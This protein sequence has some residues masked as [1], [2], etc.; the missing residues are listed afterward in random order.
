MRR[1]GLMCLLCRLLTGKLVTVIDES[2]GHYLELQQVKQVLPPMEFGKKV[3][4]EKDIARAG[5]NK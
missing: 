1:Q 4:V 3:A 5:F 2:L